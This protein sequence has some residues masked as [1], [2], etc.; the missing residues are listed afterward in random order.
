M[1]RR[2][3]SAERRRESVGGWL[4]HFVGSHRAV[5]G[6]CRAIALVLL[7]GC[8]APDWRVPPPPAGATQADLDRC[9]PVATAASQKATE[10]GGG[11]LGI[12]GAAA[13][14]PAGLIVAPFIGAAAGF[15]QAVE[16]AK[17]AGAAYET[18]MATYVAPVVLERKLGPDSPEVAAAYGAAAALL[19]A[20]G[21][22]S[23]ALVASERSVAIE[24]RVHGPEHRDTVRALEAHADL[25]RQL[26]QIGAADQAQARARLVRQQRWPRLSPAAADLG[27][28]SVDRSVETEIQIMNPGSVPLVFDSISATDPAWSGISGPVPYRCPSAAPAP[29]WS[30]SCRGC[31]RPS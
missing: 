28:V 17:P 4:T 5:K 6:C 27:A 10:R 15:A 16:N 29:S 3:C 18:A 22:P 7:A 1:T 24:E 8:A 12:G 31:R 13:A 9:R 20:N 30:G 14:G 25:L 23:E 21:S 11:G 19:A 2:R 26:G